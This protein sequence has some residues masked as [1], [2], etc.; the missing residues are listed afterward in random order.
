MFGQNKAE[1]LLRT[2][3]GLQ[4]DVVG[5]PFRTIQ[6]EGPFAGRP[7]TFLRL[8]GCHLRC[9]WCDTDF[10]SNRRHWDV[11]MLLG[12]LLA[13]GAPQLVVITGGEPMR[14]NLVPL[15]Q[16]L[17]EAGRTVQVET[18]GSYWPLGEY[19]NEMISLTSGDSGYPWQV[20]FVVSP[21][22][23]RVHPLIRAFASAWKYI[24]T[25]DD[26]LSE[27]DGLPIESTQNKGRPVTLARPGDDYPRH[28]IWV[29]P[30]DTQ[31]PIANQRAQQRCVQLALKYGYRV[32]LQQHKILE[33]P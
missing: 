21:K 12:P 18:A 7:A 27:V 3:D 19:E 33:L 17:L 11:D 5:E 9:L 31:D 20:H 4:L 22:T 16:L 15:C 10:T 24:I 14:Q 2:H 30:C 32:S 26:P 29:Q 28:N 23:P 6:G 1:P 13:P 8:G 25:N